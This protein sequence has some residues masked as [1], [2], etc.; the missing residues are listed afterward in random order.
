[1]PTPSY[2]TTGLR[3]NQQ[4]SSIESLPVTGTIPGWLQGTL[5]R[6]G[7]GMVE[8]D[9]PVRHWFDGLAMLHRFAIHNGQVSYLSRY[10]D[11]NAYRESVK[12]G[13]FTYSDFATDPCRSL[14]GK[15]QTSFTA[16]AG[17]TDSAKVNIGKVGNDLYALGEPLMQVKFDPA[18][19]K[20][21]GVYHFGRKSGSRMTTAHPHTD[22]NDAVNLVV[23]Y[24]PVNHYKI[25]S[26]QDPN[27]VLASMP[28]MHPSYMHSFGMSDRYFII[29]EFP[30][31]VRSIELAL[32]RRPFIENFKWEPDR[33]TRF[34]IIDRSTGKVK[35]RIKTPAFFG[36]HHVNAFET[37]DGLLTVDMVNYN[38]ASVIGEYY[39]NRLSSDDLEIPT[40]RLER[41]RIDV[42]GKRI[43]ERKICSETCIELPHIP[44][45]RVHGDP[46]YRYVYGC[47][48]NGS[49]RNEFYNQIVRIDIH[50]GITATW[51]Q[52]GQYPG[53]PVFVPRPGATAEDDG[54]ILSVVL[55]GST[56]RS[57]L[58]ILNAQDLTE[59]GRAGLPHGIP[60]GY[61][62]Y[63]HHN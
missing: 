23:E 7:P 13:R 62:G 44:Y 36:F 26:M 24:G 29:T 37:A 2:I 63:F 34:I 19:L 14:F 22:G 51:F 53:E 58:L 61:H 21:L 33:G 5:L 6:N 4:E 50:S 9:K 48:I 38:D 54:V 41:F 42:D 20:S 10:L 52:P 39:I 55:D 30:L 40:G 56:S 57:F 60:F 11:C 27:R 43:V 47:G 35:A 17:I 45:D 3:T 25:I 59:I 31:V 8:L 18:T 12:A 28:I 1:M 15:I 16:D 46:G 32:R 49:R